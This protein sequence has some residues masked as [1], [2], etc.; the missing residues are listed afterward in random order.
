MAGGRP[1][2]YD[3]KYC[4]MLISY[5]GKGLSIEAFAGSIE[6][7][8]DTIYE[9]LNKFPEFSDSYSVAKM[10]QADFF[11]KMGI[12]AM[13]GKI[14]GFNSATYI[15]TMK[16]KLKWTDRQEVEQNNNINITIDSDDAEM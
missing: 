15:F 2:K 13:A 16:N 12:Q 6:V 1:T 4:E 11:E 5:M 14:K 9:W 10:K 7:N 3:P 8:R